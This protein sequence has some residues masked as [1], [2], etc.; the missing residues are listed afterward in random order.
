MRAMGCYFNSQRTKQLQSQPPT[1]KQR[2]TVHK[3]VEQLLI[4]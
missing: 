4:S 3:N 1:H 2:E